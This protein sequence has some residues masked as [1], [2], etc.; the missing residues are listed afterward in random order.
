T[1]Y[2]GAI[3]VAAT[4][5][6]QAIAVAS[7]APSSV[8]SA[9]YTLTLPPPF[10]NLDA[11]TDSTTKSATIPQTDSLLVSGWV[12]D[13]TDGAPL[14]NVKVYLDGSSIGTPTLGLAR[15]DV[16]SYF[17]NS[18]YTNSG[19]QLIYPAASLSIGTHSVTVA[20]IDSGGRSTS[21]GPLTFTVAQGANPP[22]GNLDAAI[23]S[24]TKSATIPKTDSLLISGWVADPADGAPLSNVKV[25]ID[26]GLIGTPALGIARTD[27]SAYFK[28]PAYTNCGY[29]ITYAPAPLSLGMHSVTVVAVDSKG[30]STTFGPLTF[31]VAQGANP[32]FGNLDSVSDSTTKSAT[33]PQTDSLLVS[34]WVADVADGAPLSNVKVYL[35]GSAIGTPVLGIARTDVAAYF[36]NTAFTNCGYQL[37]YPAASLTIGTH[38]V[39]VVA[40]D[41]KGS[42]TTFGPFTFTVAQGAN[43]PFGNLDAAIDSTTFK[44][45]V[46]QADSLLVSGWVVD[47]ADGAPL[48][49]VM[50]YLDG[51]TIGTPV[52]GIARPDVAAYFKNSK[53]ANSGYQLTYPAASLSIG[54]HSVTVIAIDSKGTSTTFGPLTITVS[55]N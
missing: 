40:V 34:G 39:T 43:P 14:S 22:F 1:K 51:S 35:D 41:S 18:N 16:A 53:Y 6:I 27:V 29:Q 52:L 37:T 10:G 3:K 31:T 15:T 28:N 7:G 9:T 47:P 8:A 33:I 38:S 17:K 26:G 49:N 42:S 12:A 45:T 25:Y 20:A 44:S 5:T 36:K 46:L 11:A 19:F 54:T 21:F 55:G 32:S 2:T 24:T 13:T 4:E 30:S 23:D 48:S 50:V